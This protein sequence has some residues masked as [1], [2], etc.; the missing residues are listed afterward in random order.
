[1]ILTKL[2]ATCLVLCMAVFFICYMLEAVFNIDG[3]AI[4]LFVVFSFAFG[5]ISSVC[6]PIF[7]IWGL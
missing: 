7:L 1:M 3:W 2:A 5:I 4:D 6:I